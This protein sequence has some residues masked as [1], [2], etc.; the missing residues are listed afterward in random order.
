MSKL[1]GLGYASEQRSLHCSHCGKMTLHEEDNIPETLM[2]GLMGLAIFSCFL[3]LP[4]AIIGC[5]LI[6][7][8]V[9][10]TYTCQ[11]CGTKR[12]LK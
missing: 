10:D 9:K 2:M 11:T 4:V 5:M 1:V 8:T 7:F 3:L 6:P 12:K